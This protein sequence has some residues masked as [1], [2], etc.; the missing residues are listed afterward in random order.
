M[1]GGARRRSWQGGKRESE[2][3]GGAVGKAAATPAGRTIECQMTSDE[4]KMGRS[5]KRGKG[6]GLAC[7]GVAG[8][9]ETVAN[10]ASFGGGNP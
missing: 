3:G 1:T 6:E 8:F 4:G 10:L 5:E 2:G 9:G 7:E